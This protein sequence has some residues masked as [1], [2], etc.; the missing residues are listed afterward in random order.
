MIFKL[1]AII[2]YPGGKPRE[3]VTNFA[4]C[5]DAADAEAKLRA[6]VP[7]VKLKSVT[8]VPPK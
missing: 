5:T 8:E 3:L 2:Q 4:G 1:K 7:V 6:L